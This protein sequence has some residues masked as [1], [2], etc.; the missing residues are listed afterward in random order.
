MRKRVY[1][2][3]IVVMIVMALIVWKHQHN[4]SPDM[5]NI[6]SAESKASQVVPES[7]AI[8]T[9]VDNKTDGHIV[10]GHAVS[11]VM[12]S[13]PS[14]NNSPAVVSEAEIRQR[15]ATARNQSVTNQ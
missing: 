9:A 8:N 2:P 5:V 1:I 10:T 7:V 12:P 13:M 14:S 6:A 11:V 15:I 4:N 3:A